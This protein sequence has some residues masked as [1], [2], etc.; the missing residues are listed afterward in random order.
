[1][2]IESV[3][4]LVVAA[5]VPAL[6]T[7]LALQVAKLATVID[8]LPGIAKQVLAVVIAFAFVKLGGVLGIALPADLAGL[9]DP[10]AMQAAV[11]ALLA[12]VIHKL[13]A[14]KA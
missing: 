12:F 4:L 6:G 5:V 14:P 3:L 9:S 8:K 10:Q 2:S 13:F 11:G 1:M 7:Y